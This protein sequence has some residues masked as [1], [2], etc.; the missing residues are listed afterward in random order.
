[1]NCFRGLI[2]GLGVAFAVWSIVGLK[3]V[4][5]AFRCFKKLLKCFPI[6]RPMHT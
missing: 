6:S 5:A 2:G 3:C 1:M 4:L